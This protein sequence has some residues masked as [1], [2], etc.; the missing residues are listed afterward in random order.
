MRA[1]RPVGDIL[2]G[3]PACHGAGMDAELAGQRGMGGAALLDIGAGAR[4][5]GGIGVPPEL[6]QRALPSFDLRR[7]RLTKT[8]APV[9]PQGPPARR[10]AGRVAVATR[11]RGSLL[12]T[13]GT[14]CA[15]APTSRSRNRRTACHSRALSRHSS[16]TKHF[17]P[18]APSPT[19]PAS[20]TCA[21]RS[22]S[23]EPPARY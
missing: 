13:T 6:H 2:T 1:G 12:W 21:T 22:R 7:D 20:P 18:G 8:L 15:G 19:S 10:A 11:A 16:G 23:R 9:G 14:S 4:G 17:S 3:L 5:R